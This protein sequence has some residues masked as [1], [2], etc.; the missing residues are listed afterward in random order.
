MAPAALRVKFLLAWAALLLAKL[1]L[2]ATLP[3]FGDEA[4]YAWEARHPA[5]AYSDLPG[6]IA[7]TIALGMAALGEH[8]LGVR[9]PTLLFGAALPWLVWRMAR[10]I[11]DEAQAWRAALWSLPLPLLVP[12]GLLALPD[13]LLTFAGLLA[14][15]AMLALLVHRERAIP[16]RHFVQLAFALVLGALVH[17]RFLP[18]LLAGALGLI[19]AG[20]GGLRREPRLWLALVVGALAW[21][22][23]LHYNLGAEAAGLRFH[24]LDRHPWQFQ[25]RGLAQPLLQAIIT[26]PLLYGLLALALWRGWHHR[27]SPGIRFL[28][29]ASGA[30]WLFYALFAPFVDRAR[31]SLH[32]PLPAYLLAA[33]LLPGMLDEARYRFARRLAPWAAGLAAAGTLAM[34]AALAV[35]ASPV[36]TART[37]GTALYPDNFVGWPELTATLA[38][39]VAPGDAVVAD[40]FM[41]AAQ[42]AFGL[43]RREVFV[44]DHWNNHK[45]GRAAQLAAWGYDEAGIAALPP[46]RRAWL[47]FEV[48]ETPERERER[49]LRRACRW[50]EALEPVAEV[51]GPGG[52]KRF[53]VYRGV[54]GGT[55][56]GEAGCAIRPFDAVGAQPPS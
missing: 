17:Y 4:F 18:F 26:T 20:G 15:D 1:L 28:A 54:R 41:P 51:L 32:W 46:G 29:V 12:M 34:L 56:E 43:G 42:L 39:R 38:P 53:W 19:A 13:A 22:P 48:E 33:V 30:L 55:G 49:W 45:H 11:G 25:A 47:V 24:L 5:W 50:F 44:L 35:P 52:G 14:A 8:P 3:L 7:A 21:W 23:L 16:T 9:L 31:F 6:G 10:R 36:L 2:A 27:A 40:H 37:A